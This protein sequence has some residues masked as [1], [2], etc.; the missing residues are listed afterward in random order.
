MAWDRF[1]YSLFDFLDCSVAPRPVDC[2]FVMAGRPERKRYAIE[3]WREG[4]ARE[5]ILSVGRFEWRGF[6]QLGL[7]SDGGLKE[8]VD[9][10]PP[11]QRHFFVWFRETEAGCVAVKK[12]EYGSRSEIHALAEWMQSRTHR[13][14]MIVS[15]SI[16]L[17]RTAWLVRRE[18]PRL[19]PATIFVAVPEADSSIRRKKWWAASESRRLVL[20][21]LV[22]FAGYRLL[23]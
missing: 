19:Y 12:G 21:E 18:L 5:L 11:P 15:T 20:Q 8:W 9:N 1:L 13:S 4:L 7:P 23:F 6:Y 3:L 22:K 2:L 17:R 14:L 16:H 10:T